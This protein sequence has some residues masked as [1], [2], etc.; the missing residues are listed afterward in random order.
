MADPASSEIFRALRECRL[1]HAASDDAVGRLAAAVS[2]KS[3]PAGAVIAAEGDPADAFGVVVRGS[4]RVVHLAADGRRITFETARVGDPVGAVVALAGGRY[5]FY[6]EAAT[7]TRVAWLPR[8]ALF[9]LLAD[10]PDVARDVISDLAD[11]V[12]SFTSVVQSLALDVPSRLARYL[13]QAAL[14][15]GKRVP[16]G[17]RVDLGMPKNELASALGTV[18]ETLS[19]AFAKLK[20]DGLIT[21]RGSA[22]T[23][24]DV[25][26]LAALGSGY[27][28]D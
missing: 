23:I 21:V 8:E 5:P 26:S 10:E 13:F 22:V 15:S 25:R 17:V 24:L 6:V 2:V 4:A 7:D 16:S 1:W 3:A 9:G 14:A 27:S 28:E 20:A 19:R 12:V 18:P 11:R